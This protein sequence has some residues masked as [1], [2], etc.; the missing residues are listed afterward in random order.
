MNQV[1]YCSSL[2]QISLESA[3]LL[4]DIGA[5]SIQRRFAIQL[6]LS[7]SPEQTSQRAS[8]GSQWLFGCTYNSSAFALLPNVK[9]D[10]IVRLQG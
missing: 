1:G 8:H 4:V 2:I 3:N 7:S 6:G 9:V 10:D 5:L